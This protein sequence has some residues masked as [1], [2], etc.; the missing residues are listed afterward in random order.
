MAFSIAKV[1]FID[2]FKVPREQI[3][4]SDKE[5]ALP[6]VD[7]KKIESYLKPQNIQSPSWE[8]LIDYRT[9]LKKTINK[10][11]AQDYFETAS[12][13]LPDLVHCLRKDFCGM[14]KATVEAPYFDSERT[15]A[16]LLLSRTLKVIF[17]S[18]KNR[19]ELASQLD[20]N[21]ITEISGLSG[22]EV[23]AASMDLLI[24]FD[25]RNSGKEHLFEI[26]DG[27]KGAAK[28]K[29]YS[30]IAVDLI[31]EERPLFISTIEKTFEHDDA[32]TV[33][34]TVESMKKFKLDQAEIT[35]V[36][37]ALCHFK[38]DEH[39]GNW[40]MIVSQMKKVDINFEKNC[41]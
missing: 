16:H 7:I 24:N 33:I 23:K 11:N 37:K 17:E 1:Y 3:L 28:A 10:E 13:N 35:R 2:S 40:S 14:E 22:N 6:K 31:P 26:A 29:F 36:S 12:K 32:H 30:E 21:L 20:W 25:K 8:S 9:D 18:I 4:V 39:P 27:Y 15:P 5:I 38:S 34:S 19:P 41:L